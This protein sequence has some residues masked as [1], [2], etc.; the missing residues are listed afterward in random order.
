MSKVNYAAI[1]IG[2]NA[3]RLLI[4]SINPETSEQLFTK[5]LLLRVPLRLGEE[6]FTQGEIPASKAKKLLRLMK[7]YRQLMKIYEVDAYR[8]CA[9]SAMRDAANGKEVIETITRKSGIRIDIINGEEEARLVYDNHIEYLADKNADYI[10]VDVGGGSTEISLIHQGILRSSC[11]Y[12]IGTVRL[13]KGKVVP[14]VYNRLKRDLNKLREQY[15]VITIIGSGGNINKL[16]R[17][18]K[19]PAKNKMTLPVEKLVQLNNTLKNYSLEERARLYN[20]KPDRADVITNAADIFL[21]VAEH[22]QAKHIVV[23]TIGLVDGIIDSLYLQHHKTP[24]EQI[25]LPPTT[26][27][28]NT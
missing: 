1:D 6:V 20:L 4:K 23:P 21:L 10:Y 17:L 2:S 27:D 26:G 5:E 15:P 28:E 12:N 18:A 9:T 13:L 24:E 19:L 16:F 3:V 7:A 14:S 25:P 8:A 22:T 11:S